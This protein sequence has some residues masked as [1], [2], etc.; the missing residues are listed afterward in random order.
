MRLAAPGQ[1]DGSLQIF[2]SFQWPE[3]GTRIWYAIRMRGRGERCE[4]D[5]NNLAM[6]LLH[7]RP[8]LCFGAE[9]G[10]RRLCGRRWMTRVQRGEILRKLHRCRNRTVG[11]RQMSM[12]AMP[13]THRVVKREAMRLDGMAN[14]LSFFT[15]LCEKES[16]HVASLAL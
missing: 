6:K 9:G 14:S 4:G 13:R 12:T 7:L 3:C 1:D 8:R 11:A 15:R 10:R 5:G 16:S 2:V